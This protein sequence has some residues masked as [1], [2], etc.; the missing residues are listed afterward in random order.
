MTTSEIRN[1]L[2]TLPMYQGIRDQWVAALRSGEFIQ[3][4]GRLYTDDG[5]YCCL[6]V[7]CELARRAG[8]VKLN[9]ITR[10]FY[11]S[12][13]KADT[14]SSHLPKAVRE[15]AGL[16]APNPIVGGKQLTKWNDVVAVGTFDRI[17]D[18]IERDL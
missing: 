14:S 10:E 6:G 7:L 4:F 16:R 5:R 8:V 18:M 15:W 13:Q 17:A 3:G 11:S 2:N 12:G 9:E 1:I